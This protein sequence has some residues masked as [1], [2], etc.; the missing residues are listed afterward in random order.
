MDE[1]HKGMMLVIILSF[2]VFAVQ[3]S[4]SAATKRETS[5]MWLFHSVLRVTLYPVRDTKMRHFL[6]SGM[7]VPEV[8]NCARTLKGGSAYDAQ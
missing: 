4:H 2:L 8:K 5:F 6:F 3:I 1:K 7:L